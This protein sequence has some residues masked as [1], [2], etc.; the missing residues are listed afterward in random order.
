LRGI[1]YRRQDQ[2]R[3][4]EPCRGYIL[5]IASTAGLFELFRLRGGIVGTL[6]FPE[7]H[8][9]V[10]QHRRGNSAS[11]IFVASILD[12]HPTVF[13]SHCSDRLEMPL[14]NLKIR[15]NEILERRK[16][17]KEK[18]RQEKAEAQKLAEKTNRK[19]PT[20]S[21]SDNAPASNTPEKKIEP[22][23]TPS[24]LERLKK[25]AQEKEQEKES[26]KPV[27]RRNNRNARPR[28]TERGVSDHFR[29]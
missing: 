20:I 2:P 17:A 18:R 29:F 12:D 8:L 27:A 24:I 26:E 21:A 11:A 28:G 22:E 14:E 25:Q 7:F 13:L 6:L 3:F 4:A 1:L 19:T 5:F 10:R 15:L 16:I 23:K 9:F